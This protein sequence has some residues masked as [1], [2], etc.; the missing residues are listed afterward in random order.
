MTKEFDSQPGP[1]FV[2]ST[3]VVEVSLDISFDRMI[4]EA[5]P[6][7]A[8][9]QRFGRV[10]RRRS[11]VTIGKLKPV[12]VMEPAPKTLPYNREVVLRSY[13]QL[14]DAALLPERDLQ[15]CLDTVYP[16][17]TLANIDT[18]L[19][20]DNG[21]LL[22]GA[23]T[24]RSRSVLVEALEIETAACI[25]ADNRAE[26]VNEKTFWERRIELEIPISWRTI[27]FNKNRQHYERLDFGAAPFVVPQPMADYDRLGLQLLEPDSFL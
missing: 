26:Y 9:V 18:H 21:E 13:A 6:F 3:Q 5:A 15:R 4:T 19:I 17:L 7:D 23:L 1:C 24:N 10:N 20:W 16:D 22:E 14:P 8:L 11:Q 12:H 25:L 2:V 27:Q